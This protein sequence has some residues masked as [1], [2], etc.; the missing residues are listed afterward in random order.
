[1]KFWLRKEN[2]NRR[3]I[4]LI[5]YVMEENL[6]VNVAYSPVKHA[7]SWFSVRENVTH[8][9]KKTEREWHLDGLTSQVQVMAVFIQK[10]HVLHYADFI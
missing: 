7:A 4:L 3:I 9:K 1:M 6:F 5:N 10:F 8:T 2:Y